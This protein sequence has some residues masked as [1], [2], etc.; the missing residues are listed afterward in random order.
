MEV[1]VKRKPVNNFVDNKSITDH[2]LVIH[3]LSTSYTQS[4]VDL[5]TLILKYVDKQDPSPQLTAVVSAIERSLWYG[6]HKEFYFPLGEMKQPRP[7][8]N[9]PM[10][11]VAFFVELGGSIALSQRAKVIRAGGKFIN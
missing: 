2:L 1:V 10:L 7:Q 9:F 8:A 5:F 3:N 4:I 11:Q 6:W